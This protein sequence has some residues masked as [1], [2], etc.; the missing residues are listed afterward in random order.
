ATQSSWSWNA[1]K[2]VLASAD[3]NH[4]QI[5]SHLARTHLFVEP[6]IV[7]THL[8]LPGE[9]PVSLLLRPHFEGTIFINWSAIH[10]LVSNGGGVDQ[11]QAGT[12][13][14]DLKV[15]AEALTQTAFDEAIVPNGFATR[16]FGET[17]PFDYPYRDDALLL[18]EAIRDWVGSYL[19]IFYPD[20]GTV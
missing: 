3:D 7:A 11:L 20:D 14:S 18:W 2:T 5:V 9:H 6:F 8:E 1:A 12:I 16:G 17:V 19:A 10:F 15:A 13:A 4:Q